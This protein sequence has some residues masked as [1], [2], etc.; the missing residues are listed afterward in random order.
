MGDSA[1]TSFQANDGYCG[2]NY[3]HMPDSNLKN[4]IMTELSQMAQL[5][6][7]KRECHYRIKIPLQINPIQCIDRIRQQ[8]R[9]GSVMLLV[10]LNDYS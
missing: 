1:I 8:T 9:A 5:F 4:F 3:P 7:Y 2:Y 6:H 10:A